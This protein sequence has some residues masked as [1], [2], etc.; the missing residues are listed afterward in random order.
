MR[1]SIDAMGGDFA[2]AEI[3]AGSLQAAEKLQGLEKL[4]L[5]GDESAIKAE[6]AKH[7]GP[8][9]SCIEIVH[10]SEVVG[11]GESP[12]V[13]IRRKK[14]SSITRS[15]ELV[16][17]GKADAV[18]SAGN[19]GAAVAA[20]TLKLR[21]LKGVSRPA[22]A[23]VMPTP[24][25]PFVLLDAGANPDSTPEMIQQYAVMG[26]IYS[27][28]IL[29]VENPSVGLLSIGEEAAKG[30]ETTKKTFGLLEK[31]NLNFKGNVESRDLYGG[32]VSVA[33]CDGFV[34]NV[35]LKTSEAVASMIGNWLKDMFKRNIFR[36]LG[37]FL[38]RGVFKE[39]RKHADP[40]SY[41]GAPLLGANGVVIIGHG[42]STAFATLNGI[43]VATE[44]LDHDVNHLIEAELQSITTQS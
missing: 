29:G 33:V 21:T 5:V 11:M 6:L 10:C 4:Y 36:I 1:I 13:A 2:P 40:H 16:R 34:G 8:V 12:A 22:I 14:D 39:M 15:V 3:V 26:T 19:T 9:P 24:N 32:K 41:G 44:A 43:R 18:F 28:E 35:V 42:S 37:Y 20:A 23:T 25:Q 7:K 31:S 38:A 17:D 27:R 30:N